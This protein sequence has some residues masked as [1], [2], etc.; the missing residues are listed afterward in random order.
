MSLAA[1]PAPAQIVPH[2]ES[3]GFACP[4]RKEVPAFLQDLTSSR[5]QRELAGAALAQRRTSA[6]AGELLMPLE[7]MDTAFWGAAAGPGADVRA[8]LEAAL[9]PATYA[10]VPKA[11]AGVSHF[12]FAR[13]NALRP[14]LTVPS[15]AR[16]LP[17][18]MLLP[19]P[20]PADPGVPRG[21]GLLVVLLRPVLA[22][23]I[24]PA[25]T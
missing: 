20:L 25:G 8:A 14:H 5:G 17:L 15:S 19:P 6:G 3:L 1:P 16:P 4:P 18:P 2:F 12:L 10:D 21:C 11:S 24:L 22:P 23:P 7:E 13:R 9:A